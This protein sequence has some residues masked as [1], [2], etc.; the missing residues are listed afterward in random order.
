MIFS[1]LKALTYFLTSGNGPS[2][3]PDTLLP[4]ATFR[5]L[6]HLLIWATTGIGDVS[7]VAAAPG[8][9]E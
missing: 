4:R 7:G 2:Q 6:N 3:L 5:R 8:A 1:I 9:S